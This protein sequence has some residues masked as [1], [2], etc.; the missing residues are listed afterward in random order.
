M[1]T[2]RLVKGST[3]TA[4]RRDFAG[5]PPSF[6]N[7][8]T[9]AGWR[10]L[11]EVRQTPEVDGITTRLGDVV[12][13]IEDDQVVVSREVVEVP[14]E[15]VRAAAHQLVNAERQ[16]REG[17][18]VEATVGETTI[19]VDTRDERDFRN[20]L[21]LT[22]DALVS[23]AVT[24]DPAPYTFKDADNAYHE[25]SAADVLQLAKAVSSTI[26]A[27]SV[28]WSWGVKDAIDQAQDAAAVL[29]ILQA[30]GLA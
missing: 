19:P 6:G 23:L 12:E 28:S 5:Q 8:P 2:Y 26:N 1:R 13:T 29:A 27:D 3:I 11:P 20:L 10:W 17:P 4:E 15:E 18:R 7:H 30:E 25:L 21:G 9:K 14:L 22:L 24:Q 16:R